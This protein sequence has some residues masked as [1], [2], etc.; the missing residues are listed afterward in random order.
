MATDIQCSFAGVAF[1]QAPPDVMEKLERY[2]YARLNQM[3]APYRS[4]RWPGENLRRLGIPEYHWPD[5]IRVGQFF[6]PIIG[7]SRWGIFRG[8]MTQADIDKIKPL[9]WVSGALTHASGTFKMYQPVDWDTS[10]H[11]PA[12]TTAMYLLPPV[13]VMG[14]GGDERLYI[15]TLVDERYFWQWKSIT[16]CLDISSWP[17]G[18]GANTWGNYLSLICT[19]L[20][21]SSTN[22]T[23]TV[24]DTFNMESDSPFFCHYESAAALMDAVLL[25]QG[26][27]FERAVDG[28][29]TADFWSSAGN[30][31]FREYA[32]GNNSTE[33]LGMRRMMGGWSVVQDTLSGFVNKDAYR[34]T[35]P[36]QVIVTFPKWN[37]SPG[38]YRDTFKT[39]R[40]RFKN[41]SYPSVYTKTIDASTIM[42]A[43]VNYI[44]AAAVIRTA[45]KARYTNA[46][47]TS[48][49]NQ[50]SI[51]LLATMLVTAYLNQK[52]CY[53]DETF[54][55]VSANV[56]SEWAD[57]LITWDGK[58]CCT[59]FMSPPFNMENVSEFF[60]SFETGPLE[61]DPPITIPVVTELCLAARQKVKLSATYNI[62]TG[63]LA[64]V[65]QDITGLSVVVAAGE[66]NIFGD[67]STEIKV[68]AATDPDVG[69][70][71]YRLYDNTAGA[72]VADSERMG[73][74]T[75]A[76]ND[77][78]RSNATYTWRV[79]P[80]VTTTYKLQAMWH[81]D[82]SVTVGIADCKSNSDGWTHLF[83]E[84]SAH[85][86][87]GL[88]D[89]IHV[90][91]SYVDSQDVCADVSTSCC[92]GY[93]SG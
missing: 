23:G 93:G 41:D 32:A 16:S 79:D 72:A 36:K 69:Y 60:H 29:V 66:W 70:V 83:A 15:V 84:P 75:F 3:I 88:T 49:N 74:Q 31:Y 58:D 7:A 1:R 30:T 4:H 20:G 68:T 51:D 91:G 14:V 6:Y 47:D 50:S 57:H 19:A 81:A 59:R 64:D 77:R 80:S 21:I 65:W 89:T 54:P 76:I 27:Y 92:S 38:E 55:G 2:D 42:G 52:V 63:A 46:A 24:S 5:Q 56:G 62:L 10:T 26:R 22:F 87:N 67:V 28:T 12:L 86:M 85:A 53:A 11:E 13:P 34:A 18:A 73:I 17:S 78:K 9:V 40:A 35:V 61:H 90:P 82:A 39:Y 48:V 71:K 25:H 8:L 33:A 44:D 45:A 43:T 37:D